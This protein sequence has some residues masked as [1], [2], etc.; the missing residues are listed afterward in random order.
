[1]ARACGSG[2]LYSNMDFSQWVTFSRNGCGAGH[3]WNAGHLLEGQLN[4]S[5][6][7]GA[8]LLR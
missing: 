8:S 6:S 4:C 3:L 5:L 7:L 1:M 2:N